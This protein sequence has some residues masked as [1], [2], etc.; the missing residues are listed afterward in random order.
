MTFIPRPVKLTSMSASGQRHPS[1]SPVAGG[2]EIVS[3]QAMPKAPRRRIR[4]RIVTVLG[5]VIVL[6]LGGFYAREQAVAFRRFSVVHEGRL[7]RSRL[8]P[9]DT[10]REKCEKY[11]IRSVI[12]LRGEKYRDLINAEIEA[13]DAIGVT[14]LHLPSNQP[15]RLTWSLGSW[16]S[17]TIRRTGRPWYTAGMAP[18]G[19]T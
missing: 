3:D 5:V 11:G 12:D 18:V 14:H 9:I 4:R 19:R 10:L 7:I 17:W 16:K 8:L 15:P 6:A 13:L 2:S 1:E